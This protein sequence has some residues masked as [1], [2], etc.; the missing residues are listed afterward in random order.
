MGRCTTPALRTAA[1]ALRAAAFII[2]P[3]A[4]Y[5]PALDFLS[6]T[7]PGYVEVV[8]ELSELKLCTPSAEPTA[9][10]HHS[11]NLQ[12]RGLIVK[13]AHERRVPT[14][15]GYEEH[16]WAGTRLSFP[17]RPYNAASMPPDLRCAVRSAVDHSHELSEW[18]M[19]RMD[20][21]STLAEQCHPLSKAVNTCLLYTSPSPRD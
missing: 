14:S 12:S 6:T 4:A 5:T 3:G 9:P 19:R 18:R 15:D 7:P 21:S 10:A 17:G 13:P 20:A 2:A 8:Q 1:P 11:L 16:F